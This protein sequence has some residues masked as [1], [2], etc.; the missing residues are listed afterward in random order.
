MYADHTAIQIVGQLMLAFTFLG[1]ALI[2]S[3]TQVRQ[4][5]ERMAAYGIPYPHVCLWIG[6]A[7]QYAGSILVALD[8]WTETGVWLLV[9]FTV[10]ATAIF[11]RFWLVD[12]PLR[13]HIH[14]SIVFSNVGIVGGLLW[15]LP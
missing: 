15:L 7:I 6:F 13:R 4:H 12:D 10:L 8:V 11:H 1:T 5:A 14:K 3:T 9:L 2:N